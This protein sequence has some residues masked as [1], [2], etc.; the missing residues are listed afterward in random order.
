[1]EYM[2]WDFLVC[3]LRG[4]CSRLLLVRR[5]VESECVTPCDKL[6]L[7]AL[8]FAHELFKFIQ[9]LSFGVLIMI[10]TPSI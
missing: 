6:G 4:S 9:L 3:V 5:Q 8:Q 7:N 1:M 2:H 10:L